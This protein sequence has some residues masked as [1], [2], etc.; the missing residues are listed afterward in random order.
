MRLKTLDIRGFGQL[1]GVVDLETGRG[2]VA[3]LLERNEAGKSTLAAA[4]VAALYDLDSNR[5]RWRNRMTPQERYRPWT[6]GAYGLELLLERAGEELRIVRDFER[7]TTE[8]YAGAREVTS[9]F[10]RGKSV[11]V[12]EIL[13]GLTRAQFELSAF[14]PQGAIVWDDP[15]DLAE[16]LQRAADSQGGEHTAAAAIEVLQ[17]GLDQY[18]GLTLKRGQ[19][20][21][22]IQR[23]E[24]EIGEARQRLQALDARRT[25]LDDQLDRLRRYEAEGDESRSRRE[26][27]RLRRAATELD[28]EREALAVDD[29][30][31][32][33]RDELRARLAEDPALER[34][35]DEVRREVEGARRRHG[36]LVSKLGDL[37]RAMAEAGSRRDEAQAA[38]GAG[39]LRQTPSAEQV[40]E[41]GA[42]CLAYRELVHERDQL[43]GALATERTKLRG[44]GFDP[45]QAAR[46]GARFGGLGDSDRALLGGLRK[47]RVELDDEA[48]RL[49]QRLAA[50][51]AELDGV[52][53]DR[54][55]RRRAG[56]VTAVVGLVVAVAGVIAARA[57]GLA[58]WAGPLPGAVALGVGIFLAGTAPASGTGRESAAEA[59]AR[60]ADDELLR[61]DDARRALAEELQALASRLG[62]SGGELEESWQAWL[63]LQPH[64]S[65]L[66]V[67]EERLE[68]VEADEA[69]LAGQLATLEAVVGWT[70]D[71][72]ELDDLYPRFQRARANAD[73]MAAAEAERSRLA[74]DHA[75]LEVEREASETALRE[76]LRAVGVELDEATPLETGFARFEERAARAASMRQLR[77]AELAPLERQLASAEQRALRRS[78][79][80]ELGAHLQERRPVVERELARL[81]AEGRELIATFDEPLTEDQLQRE[82]RDLE[83]QT[84]RRHEASTRQLTDVRSFVEQYER[85]APALRERITELEA[86]ARRARDFAAAIELARDTL[87]EL[88]R[89]T[90]RVWSRELAARTNHMLQAMGSDIG[91]VEFDEALNLSLVQRGQRMNGTQ[92]RQALSTGARDLLHLA[93]RLALAHFL[94]G[95][96]MDLP[97]LLDDPFAHCDD[98]RTIAGMR[99]LLESVAPSH[100][101][102]LLACQ[103]SRYEWVRQQLDDPGRLRPLALEDHA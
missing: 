49:R 43:E 84:E 86:A 54:G 64:T 29:A 102:V 69:R 10:R 26:L 94:S 58:D 59:R 37:E 97:L 11:E 95:G 55:R 50:A 32:A 20:R 82:L 65:G 73:R 90:H 39:E 27:L 60:D 6:G 5:T 87:D 15:S 14:V 83:T 8:V 103:R 93:C 41:L 21:T 52:E 63:D 61:V 13:T 33:R 96:G 24:Q 31:R 101:V 75:T 12:G 100:Q 28:F 40:T 22:E 25:A 80:E 85:E 89:Q 3:L 16:A 36:I 74:E 17:A 92:A 38:L 99:V 78:R 47:R 45:A 53:S 81:G 9:E 98:P 62:C 35:T 71:P 67:L 42:F 66:A 68:R 44:A 2:T 88:A 34:I 79:I 46:L 57:V 76:Q 7:G 23:C 51:R 72:A 77:E 56:V 18:E 70:P 30:R 91:Q 19:V 48:D 4:I 1:R